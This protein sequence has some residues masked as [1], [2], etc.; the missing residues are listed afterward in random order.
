LEQGRTGSEA[1]GSN[2]GDIPYR[3]NYGYDTWNNLTTRDSSLYTCISGFGFGTSYVNNRDTSPFLSYDAAGNITQDRRG[4]TSIVRQHTYDVNGAKVTATDN[5]ITI[6]Q[7]YSGDG[8]VSKRVE[9]HIAPAYSNTTYYLRSSVFGGAAITEL[10]AQGQKQK[11]YIFA[12]SEILAEHLITQSGVGIAWKHVNPVTNDTF[13]S[14]VNGVYTSQLLLDPLGAEV[15]FVDPCLDNQNPDYASE[16]G[17]K[18]LYLEGGDPFDAKGGCT[19]DGIAISCNDLLRRIDSGSVQAQGP[20]GIPGEVL[21][22]GGGLIYG[23]YGTGS[24]LDDEGERVI[25]YREFSGR[26]SFQ[27]GQRGGVQQPERSSC[28]SFVDRVVG[29]VDA[30]LK[31]KSKIEGLGAR[32]LVLAEVARR[33]GASQKFDGFKEVYT[34]KANDKVGQKWAVYQHVYGFMGASLIGN[35]I[36]PEEVQRRTGAKTGIELVEKQLKEDID[37]RD[38]PEKYPEK[39]RQGIEASQE[40]AD[41]LAGIA[42]SN[43]IRGRINSPGLMNSEQLRQQLFT[44]FCDR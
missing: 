42:A 24:R 35:N 32:F 26:L 12:N 3:Q 2:G 22:L 41:D 13:R 15:G 8:Q 19:L 43:L 1:W 10:N 25:D 28:G 38:H 11:G 7:S 31:Y 17:A 14:D 29:M 30:T 6:M 16:F 20:R 27:G 18:P 5:N 23:R 39:D 33:L 40:V 44:L 21:H 34:G 37:Q 36:L 9:T 4:N